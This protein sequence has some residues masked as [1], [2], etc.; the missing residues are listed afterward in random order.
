[1]EGKGASRVIVK[2]LKREHGDGVGS[3]VSVVDTDTDTDTV[4][5]TLRFSPF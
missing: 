3:G 5:P 4:P 1:M 2:I